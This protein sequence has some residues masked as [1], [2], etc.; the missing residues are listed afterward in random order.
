MVNGYGRANELPALA[1]GSAI[2]FN[3]HLAGGKPSSTAIG[4]RPAYVAHVFIAAHEGVTARIGTE[5]VAAFGLVLP[6]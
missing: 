6:V 4:D 3:R 5:A 2:P 1:A